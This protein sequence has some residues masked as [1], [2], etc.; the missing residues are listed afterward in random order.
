MILLSLLLAC[1]ESS[2]D[3]AAAS[4]CGDA[5]GPGTDTGNLPDVLGSWTSQFATDFYDDDCTAASLSATSE[6]WIGALTLTG[7]APQA[8][9][10][11]WGPLDNPNGE[12]FY[13]VMDPRGGVSFSGTREHPA[14]TLHAQF[15]GL[16]YDDPVRGRVTIRGSA[17]LGLDADGDGGI[18]CAA[19]GSWVAFKSGG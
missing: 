9:R 2:S 3:T 19:R 12:P 16:V 5:D 13:G 1:S 6:T 18:D 7:S 4:A 17:M 15:G 14:G 10:L 11:A 8:L